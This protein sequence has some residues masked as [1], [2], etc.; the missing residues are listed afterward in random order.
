DA[1]LEVSYPR[2]GPISR[3]GAKSIAAMT[4]LAEAADGQWPLPDGLEPAWRNCVFTAVHDGVAINPDELI[5]WI[6][7]SGW[8]RDHAVEI[9]DRF[10]RDA[11][12]VGEYEEAGRQPT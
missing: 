3:V 9:A 8:S 11:T 10:Y 5:E 1:G 2:L 12:R 6:V 7:A 4:A